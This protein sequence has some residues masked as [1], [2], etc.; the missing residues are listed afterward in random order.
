MSV[1]TNPATGAAEHAAAY[2]RAILEL[3]G[4]RDPHKVLRTTMAAR[5]AEIEGLSSSQLRQPEA[6]GKWSTRQVVLHLA[7]SEVV[8]AWRVR[9]VLAH[10]QP[11]ITTRSGSAMPRATRSSSPEITSCTSGKPMSPMMRSRQAR[12]YPIDPR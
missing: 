10:D 8:F 5:P 7:D 9:L 3:L 4:D 1:F 11:P 6:P 2:T 12:P